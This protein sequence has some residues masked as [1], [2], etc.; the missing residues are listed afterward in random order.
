[1]NLQDRIAGILNDYCSSAFEA[2][3]A[4]AT[5]AI[6][7]LVEEPPTIPNNNPDNLPPPNDTPT[8][9]EQKPVEPTA[10]KVATKEWADKFLGDAQEIHDTIVAPVGER[11]E[12]EFDELWESNNLSRAEVD[13]IVV[14]DFIHQ[15]IKNREREI[16]EGLKKLRCTEKTAH[17]YGGI[18]ENHG[19]LALTYD[20]KTLVN[21]VLDSVDA[22]INKQ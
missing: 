22:L 16:A 7:A 4:L 8:V 18:D 9:S 13:R 3:R 1:M 15:T 2:D 14:L 20:E 21:A 11:W 17:A 19:L 12:S 10:P 6:L 5:K